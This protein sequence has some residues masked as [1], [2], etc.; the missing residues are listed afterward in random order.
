VIATRWTPPPFLKEHN[1][2]NL[3][4]YRDNEKVMMRSFAPMPADDGADRSDGKVV[5][6]A[7][8]PRNGDAG[9]G[10]YFKRIRDLNPIARQA[11]SRAG[12]L[13]RR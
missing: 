4:A 13:Q 12:M 3:A 9:G 10:A 5:A 6:K 8:G 7:A 2:G 1:A 11:G